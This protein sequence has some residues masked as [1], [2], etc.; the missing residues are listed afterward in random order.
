MAKSPAK[1]KNKK[2]LQ[3][4]LKTKKGIVMKTTLGTIPQSVQILSLFSDKEMTTEEV[5][6]VLGQGTLTD[7]LEAGKIG[8]LK[9]A[10][11]DQIRELLGL[12]RL[13]EVTK[14]DEAFHK[15]TNYITHTFKIMVD[16][17]MP[18]EEAV[19]TGRFDWSNENITS[20]N[21]PRPTGGKKVEK[22]VFIFHF[23]R[24]VSSAAVIGEIYKA[25]YKPAT[26]WDLIGLAMK[27]PN[28]QR[29]FPVVALGSVCKLG[30][31]RSVPCLYEDDSGRRLNLHY[32][33]Y[34]WRDSSRFLVVRD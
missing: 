8:S 18:V 24:Q 20:Q 10:D 9:N 21:F 15:I 7:I 17:T 6:L 11:R 14:T 30:G 28:F 3:K 19:K 12:K 22:E 32:F 33:D 4:K 2:L 34:G 25:R 13:V 1:T 27:E 23:G 16:E 31:D 5:Q 26:I 29:Q